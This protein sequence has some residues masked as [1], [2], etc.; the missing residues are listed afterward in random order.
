MQGEEILLLCDAVM[1]FVQEVVGHT[2]QLCAFAPIGTSALQG[3]AQVALARVG[4]AQC[5][6]YKGF[7]LDV[8]I[9]VYLR[10]LVNPQFAGKNNALKSYLFE[11]LY[12]GESGVVALCRGMQPQGWQMS[13]EKTHILNDESI[14][15]GMVH[16]PCEMLGLLQFVVIENGIECHPYFCSILVG[17]LGQFVYILRRI[18][19]RLSCAEAVSPDVNSIC[20]TVNGGFA[21]G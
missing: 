19:S 13:F 6:V 18:G 16:F 17:I 15:T 2:A 8:G 20:A 10:Y 3:F 12:L 7:Q 11:P 14:G 1:L 9:V 21:D 5:S 4:H